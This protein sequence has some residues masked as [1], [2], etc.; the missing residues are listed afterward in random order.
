[1]SCARSSGQHCLGVKGKFRRVDIASCLNLTGASVVA[2]VRDV[3]Y[4]EVVSEQAAL[5]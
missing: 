1:M 4:V 5:V 2:E 3:G